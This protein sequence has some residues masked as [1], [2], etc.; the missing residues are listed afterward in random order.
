MFCKKCGSVLADKA[1][2]RAKCGIRVESSKDE[3]KSGKGI[4]EISNI[5]L[6]KIRMWIIN[7]RNTWKEWQQLKGDEQYI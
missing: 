6:D 4:K 3:N 2:F 1:Q 7:Y 5:I